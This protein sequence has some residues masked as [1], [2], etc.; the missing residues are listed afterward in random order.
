MYPQSSSDKV[1]N[2]WDQLSYTVVLPQV[3]SCI[4]TV[5]ACYCPCKGCEN[6]AFSK[7]YA[8]QVWEQCLVLA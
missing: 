4:T 8:L 6:R 2:N 7:L 5:F 3:S 1:I